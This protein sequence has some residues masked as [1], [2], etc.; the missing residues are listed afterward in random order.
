[1]VKEGMEAA[2]SSGGTGYTF[3]DFEPRAGCKTGTAETS[4]ESEPHAWF[5]VFAPV[6]FP[7]ITLTV[8]VEK[9]GEGSKVAGPIAKEIFDFWFHGK[10]PSQ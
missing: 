9:G 5:T 1:M 4:L 10:I 7:E 8:L 6:D 2:C 3:F